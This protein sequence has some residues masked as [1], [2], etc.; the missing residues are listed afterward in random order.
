MCLTY[1]LR[2]HKVQF[3][4]AFNPFIHHILSKD[5]TTQAIEESLLSKAA[6]G[7]AKMEECVTQRIIVPEHQ[8]RPPISFSL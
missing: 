1:I 2:H 4:D 7:R 8:L 5:L 6:F 3:A